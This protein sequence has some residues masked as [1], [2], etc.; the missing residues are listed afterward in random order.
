MHWFWNS[1]AYYLVD[2]AIIVC[3]GITRNLQH[4]TRQRR[5]PSKLATRL[6]Y[7]AYVINLTQIQKYY[8]RVVLCRSTGQAITVMAINI[9]IRTPT[10]I[11]QSQAF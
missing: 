5:T 10:A 7:N 11:S 8:H 9:S 2:N 3:V 1:N 4:I 6:V